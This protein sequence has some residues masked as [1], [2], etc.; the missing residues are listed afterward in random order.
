MPNGNVI[1]FLCYAISLNDEMYDKLEKH[2][3]DLSYAQTMR[4]L[5]CTRLSVQPNIRKSVRCR[6]QE[7]NTRMDQALQKEAS[8]RMLSKISGLICVGY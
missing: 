5:V 6:T 8:K 2:R 1:H 3:D 4:D 7:I